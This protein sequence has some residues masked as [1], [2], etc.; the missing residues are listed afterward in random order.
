[1]YSNV[2]VFYSVV[3]VDSIVKD[4]FLPINMYIFTGIA[5][6]GIYRSVYVA[7]KP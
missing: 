2:N 1:M 3:P 6:V 4:V 7:A 5:E